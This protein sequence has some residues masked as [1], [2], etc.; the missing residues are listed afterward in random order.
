MTRYTLTTPSY[1]IRS[2]SCRFFFSDAHRLAKICLATPLILGPEPNP[3]S[4]RQDNQLFLSHR[5]AIS[6]RLICGALVDRLKSAFATA[7]GGTRQKIFAGGRTRF[8][9][10]AL[11]VNIGSFTTWLS[12]RFMATLQRM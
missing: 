12:R 11:T 4:V 8:G 6:I 3:S 2:R 5:S 9:I 1:E 10:A 7:C